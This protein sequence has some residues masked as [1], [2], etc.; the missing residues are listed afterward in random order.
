MQK[1]LGSN[2]A[3]LGSMQ[4]LMIGGERR[5]D[6]RSSHAGQGCAGGGG[7]TSSSMAKVPFDSLVARK[8]GLAHA[9]SQYDDPLVDFVYD[10]NHAFACAR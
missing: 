1:D 7:L 8:V 4:G 2:D 6:F 3:L 10:Q 9:D 5:C